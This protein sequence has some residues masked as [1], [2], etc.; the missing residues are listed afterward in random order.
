MQTNLS[1]QKFPLVFQIGAVWGPGMPSAG[2]YGLISFKE[3]F[4][5]E[6]VEIVQSQKRWLG[7]KIQC[8]AHHC[9]NYEACATS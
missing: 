5:C 4:W 1:F 6:D 7:I 3:T 2:I 8:I 9:D